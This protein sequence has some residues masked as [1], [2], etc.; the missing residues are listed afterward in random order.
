MRE[1]VYGMPTGRRWPWG[2]GGQ[3]KRR[4]LWGEDAQRDGMPM[5]RRCPEGWGAHGEE[6]SIGCPGVLP[7]RGAIYE[8]EVPMGMGCPREGGAHE[9]AHGEEMPTGM[10]RP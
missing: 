9:G 8:E 1:G 6:V 3:A 7:M 10:G 4:C 2:E 5:G